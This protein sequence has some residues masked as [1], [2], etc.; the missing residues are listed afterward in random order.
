[1]KKKTF[2]KALFSVLFIIVMVCS[3]N[4]CQA[5]TTSPSINDTQTTQATE[6]NPLTAYEQLND[7]EKEFFDAYIIAIQNFKAPESARL[8]AVEYKYSGNV[9]W[10]AKISATN[11]YGGSIAKVYKIWED[12]SEIFEYSIQKDLETPNSL[13]VAKINKA[14]NEYFGK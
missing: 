6:T 7:D 4:S 12:G 11:S 5:S 1:M 10:L 13:S 8:L 3:M 2:T 9:K 14:V